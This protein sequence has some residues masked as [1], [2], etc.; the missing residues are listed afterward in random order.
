MEE[1]SVRT[2]DWHPH[3]WSIFSI[4]Q[5]RKTAAPNQIEQ[6]HKISKQIGR[7]F[8]DAGLVETEIVV[9]IEDARRSHSQ[10]LSPVEGF[11]TTEL[12]LDADDEWRT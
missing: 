9:D 7:A 12:P 3:S 11:D 6:L 5:L 1:V 8:P 2:V 10:E 4:L